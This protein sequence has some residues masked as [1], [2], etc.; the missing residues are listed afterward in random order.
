MTN[1]SAEWMEANG[2][3]TSATSADDEARKA[4]E[5]TVRALLDAI[6]NRDK[7]A[8]RAAFMPEA[9]LVHSRDGAISTRTVQQL[10]DS[11][12]GGTSQLEERVH[13]TLTRIDDDIAV[14]WA[15][16][17]FRYDGVVHHE[18]T[19]ILSLM[20]QPDGRWLISGVTDNGRSAARP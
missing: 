16:Y 3:E 2:T 1:S 10:V 5:A 15:P 8:L 17:E 9:L 18:G 19:N 6:A 13:D 7:D 4:I 14:V 11:L 20:R 12:P